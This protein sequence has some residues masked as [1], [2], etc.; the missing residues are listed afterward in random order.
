MIAGLAAFAVASG[1]VFLTSFLAVSLLAVEDAL[2]KALA[3]ITIALSQIVVSLLVSGVLLDRLE[4]TTVLV[5]NGAFLLVAVLAKRLSGHRAPVAVST[6]GALGSVWAVVQETRWL[7]VLLGLVL[8]EVIW[9]L[10]AACVLPPSGFDA[11]WT[12]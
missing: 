7:T 1:L 5:V 11:L 12:T 8:A 2:E 4:P 6:R 10:V 9:R 3:T